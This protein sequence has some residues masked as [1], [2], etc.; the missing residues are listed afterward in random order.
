VDCTLT[1]ANALLDKYPLAYSLVRPPGPHE[2]SL[3]SAKQFT[4]HGELVQPTNVSFKDE[5]DRRSL[6]LVKLFIL[7]LRFLAVLVVVP[8]VL[9]M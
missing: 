4:N 2:L 3:L 1:A 6:R 7:L 5:G 9:R 8:T